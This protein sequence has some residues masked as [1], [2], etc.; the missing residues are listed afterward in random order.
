MTIP[1]SN[2]YIRTTNL[3]LSTWLIKKQAVE[4]ACL[5]TIY[6]NSLGSVRPRSRNMRNANCTVKLV[7]E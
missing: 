5:T 3:I 4:T 2:D 6:F 1:D 7:Y